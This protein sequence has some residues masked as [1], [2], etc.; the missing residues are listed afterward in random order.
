MIPIDKISSMNNVEDNAKSAGSHFFDR[1]TMRFFRSRIVAGPYVGAGRCLFVTSERRDSSVA[2]GYT[3]R[4][5][6]EDGHV[7][8]VGEFQGYKTGLAAR[9]ACGKLVGWPD[10]TGV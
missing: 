9:K 1:D 3:V 10:G 5:Q 8:T 7:H 6:T 2:R 4:E